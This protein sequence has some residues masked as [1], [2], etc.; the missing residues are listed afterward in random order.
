[1]GKIGGRRRRNSEIVLIGGWVTG[2]GAEIWKK[3]T[4]LLVWFLGLVIGLIHLRAGVGF[5][6]FN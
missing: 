5:W 2:R 6:V 4:G 3:E 1:M